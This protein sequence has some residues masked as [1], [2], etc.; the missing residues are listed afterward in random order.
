MLG[1][2]AIQVLD[3]DKQ[4]AGLCRSLAMQSV[5][6]GCITAWHRH[7]FKWLSVVFGEPMFLGTL[8]W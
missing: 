2:K 7:P 6:S 4:A 8:S 1:I 3:N 5:A